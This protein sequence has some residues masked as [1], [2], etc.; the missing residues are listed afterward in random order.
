MLEILAQLAAAATPG[1]PVDW[2]AITWPA[3]DTVSIRALI[4][5]DFVAVCSIRTVR[6]T[7]AG[8]ARLRARRKARWRERQA[9]ARARAAAL[10]ILHD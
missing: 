8:V 4:E 6:V 2:R 10:A 7:P 9:H 3:H 1:E 5:N